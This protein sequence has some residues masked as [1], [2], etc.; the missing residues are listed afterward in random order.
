MST[1]NWSGQPVRMLA[2]HGLAHIRNT[3]LSEYW[4]VGV[5]SHY[6]DARGCTYQAPHENQVVSVE[7][8][9]VML[10]PMF[11]LDAA[12]VLQQIRRGLRTLATAVQLGAE[13]ILNGPIVVLA[14]AL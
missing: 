7:E 12:W 2:I 9:S 1:Q 6:V 11:P 4:S 13:P 5:S 8:V 3:S 10:A 14:V